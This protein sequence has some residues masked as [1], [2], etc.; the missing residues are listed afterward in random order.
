MYVVILAG[1]GGTRL[2]PLSSPER[3]KPFLPLLGDRTLLQLSVDRLLAGGELG[4]GPEDVTVVTDRR[5]ADLVRGQV[6]GVSVLE[7][8]IGRNTAAAVAL[9]TVAIERPD[10]EVMLVLPA[11]QTIEREGVFRA[12]LWAAARGLARGAFG[13]ASP[14]VTLGIEVSR[15]ATEYGYL[16]PDLGSGA[17]IEGLMAYPLERFQEKPTADVALELQHRPG[18]AWN[19]GI[20]LWR[21]GAI[22]AA[23]GEFAPDVLA[24]VGDGHRSATLEAAY[25]SVRPTSI[26]YAVMEP[27]ATGG[28]VVM[29]AMDVGW[30]DLGGWTV[31]LEALGGTGVGR[32]IQAGE[33]AQAGPGDLVVERRD[34]LLTLADGPR[35]ILGRSPSA[36]LAGAR[37][38]R[39]IVEALLDRVAQEE[40]RA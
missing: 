32:V 28:R 13:I 37:P 8:P 36:L 15:P 34:G 33:A 19:A 31:L 9:S 29:G 4:L 7:E 2:W 17:E 12:T 23:L 5:Y 38:A 1:G 26:D 6:P 30:N 22:R 40:T 18:V 39:A 20:F 3:P 35:G 10:D 21:R 27:A 14:L 25:E 16:I 24:I 11:D